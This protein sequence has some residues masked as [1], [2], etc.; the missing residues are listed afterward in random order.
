MKH[1]HFC[2]VRG[3]PLGSSVGNSFSAD[4]IKSRRSDMMASM[5]SVR[6]IQRTVI[7]GSDMWGYCQ[8]FRRRIQIAGW[9][10]F[11]I[12]TPVSNGMREDKQ[13]KVLVLSSFISTFLFT[14]LSPTLPKLAHTL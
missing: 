14:L 3:I 6:Y 8:Y 5:S 12:L 1:H 7:E 9:P 2:S 4:V 11:K 13:G 10:L